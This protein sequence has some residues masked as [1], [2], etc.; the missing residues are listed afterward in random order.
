M[1]LSR[2]GNSFTSVATSQFYDTADATIRSVQLTAGRPRRSRPVASTRT[3]ALGRGVVSFPPKSHLRCSVT[4]DGGLH[5]VH[6]A[7][8]GSI[9]TAVFRY[10][11]CAM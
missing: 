4:P 11:Y 9:V 8:P 10:G 5:H 6:V 1:T 2:D 3:R 7:E